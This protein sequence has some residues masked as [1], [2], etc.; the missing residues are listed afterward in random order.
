MIAT[1]EMLEAPATSRDSSVDADSCDRTLR[2]AGQRTVARVS[3]R[4]RSWAS[5]GKSQVV[6][7]GA[8]AWLADSD[9]DGR[10]S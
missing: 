3:G 9:S 10:Q 4:T 6:F 7:N 8:P 2:E 5:R 1:L